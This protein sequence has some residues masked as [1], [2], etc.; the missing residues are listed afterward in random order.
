[1]SFS[2]LIIAH[3]SGDRDNW[4]DKEETAAAGDRQ[5]HHTAAGDRQR[6][7]K[8]QQETDREILNSSR[9]QTERY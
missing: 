5:R 8:Q 2:A 7:S 3:I 9:R 1:M 6:G 4:R